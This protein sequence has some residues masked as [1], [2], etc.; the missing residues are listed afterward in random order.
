MLRLLPTATLATNLSSNSNNITFLLSMQSSSSGSPE[1]ANQLP[2]ELQEKILYGERRPPNSNRIIGAHSPQIKND[3]NF[4]V[5]IIHNN[6]DGTTFVESIKQFP[7]G[8]FSRPKK[9]TLAPDS[10]SDAKIIDVTNQ[11]AN[12]P[13]IHTRSADG[14]TFHRET[15]DGVE[16]LVIK[17]A[18]GRIESSYP[19]GGNPITF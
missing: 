14:V 12:T 5:Q 6:S 1:S 16:W 4:T 10:W 3:P 11:V 19:K 7:D 2:S 17:D 18:A 8:T 13:T 15:V 9:S